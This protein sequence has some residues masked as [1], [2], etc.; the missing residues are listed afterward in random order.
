MNECL[1]SE[2]EE[3]PRGL[4]YGFGYTHGESRADA[5]IQGTDQEHSLITPCP[6][7]ISPANYRNG[8]II[9]PVLW[10]WKHNGLI[11]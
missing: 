11:T 5:G 10:Y 7:L 2:D 6:G 4:F 8:G 9:S 3:N 1:N